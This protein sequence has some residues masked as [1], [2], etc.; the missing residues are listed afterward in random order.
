[1]TALVTREEMERVLAER[2]RLLELNQEMLAA[3]EPFAELIPGSL[4]GVGGG[5]LV[6]P[7]V[8]IQ[9]VRDAR[10]AIAKSALAKAK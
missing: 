3:L 1:M 10:A 9:S 4:D 2:D 5:T 8:K 6:Q 7:T